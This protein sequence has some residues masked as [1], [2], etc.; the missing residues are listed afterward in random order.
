MNDSTTTNPARLALSTGEIFDG[1][2]F[3]A[4]VDAQG[5]VVFNTA[6]SGYEESMTDPSYMGQILVQTAAMIGNT[7]MN[8]R[9]ME[10]RRIQISGLV[11][12]EHVD[13]HSN[14]RASASLH[15]AM[16]QSG[17]PGICGVDTRAITSLLRS[18]GV[19]QGILSTDAKVSDA[20][21]F[22]RAQSLQSM[23]GSVF[24]EEAS[25][26]TESQW[27]QSST[28]WNH[29]Q[30]VDESDRV[31]VGVID[32]GIKENILR[33]LV[34]VGCKPIVF[35]MTTEA[36][37]MKQQLLDGTI[38]GLFLSNGPGDP[39]AM[40]DLIEKVRE[41]LLDPDLQRFPFFGICLGHQ[42][43]SLAHGA[44]TFKLKFGHRGINHPI[45][46]TKTG[47][48]SISSQN[49]GFA[50]DPST[51]EPNGLTITHR[52]LNDDTVAGIEAR[53]GL[54]AGMQFHPEASPGPHDTSGFFVRFSEAVRSV[55][56]TTSC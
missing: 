55:F 9:D 11:I 8:E 33:C 38:S 10:S 17:I 2:A 22:Q 35:P 12:H 34:D 52:H 19:V 43:L 32:C 21:L 16:E 50:V 44:S 31:P 20:E 41:L 25:T 53:G 48:V 23:A 29:L 45:L 4:S 26:C 47:K 15:K 30:G 14:Y 51:C 39:G 18:Q 5:E 27:E 1:R 28:Q 24:G 40:T 49:H 46:E 54:V 42:I 6:M 37:E 56:G 7:G 13:A 3:G 36:S